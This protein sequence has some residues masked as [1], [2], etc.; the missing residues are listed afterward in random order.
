MVSVD[1]KSN[2]LTLSDTSENLAEMLAAIGKI[3]VKP[4]GP[5]F[6]CSAGGSLRI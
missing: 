5:S 2:I 1:P 3:D 4:R 6:Y